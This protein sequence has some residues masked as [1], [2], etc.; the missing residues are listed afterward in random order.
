MFSIYCFNSNTKENISTI[1]EKKQ[2]IYKSRGV[3]S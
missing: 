2:K 1:K 3:V